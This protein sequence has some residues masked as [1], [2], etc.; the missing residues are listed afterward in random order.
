MSPALPPSPPRSPPPAP[1]AITDHS[2]PEWRRG[3]PWRGM[4][5]QDWSSPKQLLARKARKNSHPRP[6]S[7]VR[8]HSITSS[9]RSEPGA[10]PKALQGHEATGG[11]DRVNAECCRPW[12]ATQLSPAV[13]AGKGLLSHN[14]LSKG[15]LAS[16]K[17]SPGAK[18]SKFLSAPSA[19]GH[20]QNPRAC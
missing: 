6:G 13:R 5:P 15:I 17:R 2:D 19:P 10:G 14:Q 20:P 3:D 18:R 7:A 4:G 9:I 12:A 16:G 11:E 1:L 8:C